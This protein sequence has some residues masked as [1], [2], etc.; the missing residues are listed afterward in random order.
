MAY[1]SQLAVIFGRYVGVGTSRQAI[2]EAMANY[3]KSVGDGMLAERFW[4]V[5][6]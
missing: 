1:P 3:A 2:S 5:N 6:G 4:A